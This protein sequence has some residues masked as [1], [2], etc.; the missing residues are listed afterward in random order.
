MSPPRPA[1]RYRWTALALVLLTGLVSGCTAGLPHAVT[2]QGRS[3]RGQY[4]IILWIAI[5]VFVVVEVAI[6]W[7]AIRYRQRPTDDES[8]PP[9]IHG[10]TLVEV[11]WFAVP[12]A[13][14]LYIFVPSIVTLRTVDAKEA[15]PTV[16]IEVTGFQWQ[17]RFKYLPDN[18]SVTGSTDNPPE[19]VIPVNEAVR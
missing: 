18:V 3:V 2:K 1:G 10:N 5:A 15:N 19:L 13:I 14:I 9:Q 7:A 8:L 4:V 6:V 17:W 16:H 11:I 12:F